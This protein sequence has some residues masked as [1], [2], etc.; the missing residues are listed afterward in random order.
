MPRLIRYERGNRRILSK[1]K[2]KQS[3]LNKYQKLRTHCFRWLSA[4]NIFH[5]VRTRV[6]FGICA[7]AAQG[8]AILVLKEFR[9]MRFVN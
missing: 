8:L 3:K 5:I 9:E 7:L 2:H 1:Y 4:L 6:D